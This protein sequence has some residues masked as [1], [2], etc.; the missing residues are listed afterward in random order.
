ML[1]RC[2]SAKTISFEEDKKIY[3]NRL[4]CMMDNDEKKNDIQY[5]VATENFFEFEFKGFKNFNGKI[6]ENIFTFDFEG[7]HWGLYFVSGSNDKVCLKIIDSKKKEVLLAKFLISFR[8]TKDCNRYA[9][10]NVSSLYCFNEDADRRYRR[11]S[12]D[13]YT[14]E[15]NYTHFLN[16][17]KPLVRKNKI[18]VGVYLRIYSKNEIKSFINGLKKFLTY[19]KDRDITNQNL[20]ERV[21]EDWAELGDD[22]SKK[23]KMD[24]YEWEIRLYKNFL[25]STYS[26]SLILNTK[27][28]E[29]DDYIYV[30]TL[31][32]IRNDNDFSCIKIIP[33]TKCKRLD[34]RYNSF[35]FSTKIE[36]IELV[37]KNAILDKSILENNKL[38]YGIY[39]RTFDN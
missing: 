12:W 35:N 14:Q 15:I 29:I 9:T 13:D 19:D 10:L 3:I 6:N 18:I 27:D 28:L 5:S 2:K 39:I 32:Y 36:E 1:T 34:R 17:I 33:N 25:D 24:G 16:N 20:F 31:F 8:N 21:I 30:N 11:D 38:V 23:F 22:S 37:L 4:K 26:I 7:R